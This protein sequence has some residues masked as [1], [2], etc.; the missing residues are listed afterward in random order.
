[1]ERRRRLP[2]IQKYIKDLTDDDFRVRLNGVVVE[3][4][5]ERYTAMIDD[6]TG[7]AII[8]FIDPEVFEKIKEG[9]PIRIIGKLV[10]GEE[11][12]IDAEIAQDMSRLDLGLYNRARYVAEKLG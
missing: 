8:Q 10:P 2:A 4:Q 5:R 3:I 12:M 11:T 1:M 7:R 6:G 9:G